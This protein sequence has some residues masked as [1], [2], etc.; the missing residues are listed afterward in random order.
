[1]EGIPARALA[2]SGGWRRIDAHRPLPPSESS[3]AAAALGLR[4]DSD[5]GPGLL[6]VSGEGSLFRSGPPLIPLF[7]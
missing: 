2:P 7:I 5:P 4:L 3:L 1:M 6:R